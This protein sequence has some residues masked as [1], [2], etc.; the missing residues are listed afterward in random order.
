M[1]VSP[2]SLAAFH[3]A[4]PQ[5]HKVGIALALGDDLDQRG[6]LEGN[7]RTLGLQRAYQGSRGGV[8]VKAADADLSGTVPER[9]GYGVQMRLKSGRTGQHQENRSIGGHGLA[10]IQQD[11]CHVLVQVMGFVEQHD[12]CPF[13]A[14]RRQQPRQR[15]RAVAQ[16]PTQPADADRERK[17]LRA[18]RGETARRHQLGGQTIQA[19]NVARRQPD[20]VDIRLAASIS[21]WNQRNSTVLPLPRGPT[22]MAS[23]GA[24][25]PCS[26]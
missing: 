1:R 16:L 12:K 6:I 3:N 17:R 19:P 22:T 11:G 7:R 15:R 21:R 8:R 9:G 5:L 18:Q 10:C 13:S 2:V 24:P 23:R 20:H 14:T 4:S 25:L 26:R